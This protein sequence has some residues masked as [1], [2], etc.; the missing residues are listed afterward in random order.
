VCGGRRRVCG[1][2]VAGGLV[3]GGGGFG[4]ASGLWMAAAG[5]VVCRAGL[6][7]PQRLQGQQCRCWRLGAGRQQHSNQQCC[8]SQPPR[9]LARPHLAAD[10]V[11]RRAVHL[12]RAQVAQS[13]VQHLGLA[14]HQQRL[15]GR[16]GA[17]QGAGQK[18]GRVQRG[19]R[20]C[21]CSSAAAVRA[22]G[23]GGGVC[24]RGA[25]A[26]PCGGSRAQ[27]RG[28]AAC[29]AQPLKATLWQELSASARARASGARAIAPAPQRQAARPAHAVAQQ[30]QDDAGRQPGEVCAVE[31]V[32]ACK[33]RRGRE[34]P[35]PQAAAG[36]AA[37]AFSS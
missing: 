26:R 25:G 10:V 15:R 34:A 19:G 11:R 27:Q 37:A 20:M 24:V 23:G 29:T 30:L 9:P 31:D 36:D 21:V 6:G 1:G 12:C 35:E 18:V 16:R 14:V 3:A 17:R 2:L 5:G 7:L 33:R 22:D 32:E 8:C 4:R 28:S 13:A